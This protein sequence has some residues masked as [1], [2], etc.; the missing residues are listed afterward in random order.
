MILAK[1]VY[2]A[3]K[4]FKDQQDLHKVLKVFKVDQA[5]LGLVFKVT[6]VFKVAA[7]KVFKDLLDQQDSDFKVL[8]VF[9]VMMGH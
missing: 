8:K 5:K 1:L 4:V 9:K 6:K 2:K 3:S 7:D